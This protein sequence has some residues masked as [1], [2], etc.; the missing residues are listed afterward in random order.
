MVRP[1][2]SPAPSTGG[3]SPWE[4]SSDMRAGTH[5]LGELHLMNKYKWP[6]G[7]S[8]GG[9]LMAYTPRQEVPR[10][11]MGYSSPVPYPDLPSRRDASSITNTPFTPETSPLLSTDGEECTT[12]RPGPIISKRSCLADSYRRN[13]GRVEKRRKAPRGGLKPAVATTSVQLDKP[14]SQHMKD[15]GDIEIFD[16]KAHVHRDTRKSEVAE[17]GKVK[18]P[19]NAFLL[20]RK[21]V[22]IFIKKTFLAEEN[23]NNQQVVSRICGDSWKME[24]DEIKAKFK[25]LAQEEKKMHGK[26]FPGYKYTPKTGKKPENDADGTK[27]GNTNPKSPLTSSGGRPGDATESSHAVRESQPPIYRP[28]TQAGMGEARAIQDIH[29][30]GRYALASQHPQ[31]QLHY[32]GYSDDFACNWNQEELPP[33]GCDYSLGTSADMQPRQLPVDPSDV[34]IDPTFLPSMEEPVY[35]WH[36]TGDVMRGHQAWHPQNYSL[37]EMGMTMPDLDV[38]GAHSAYLRGAQEDWEIEQ[39]GESGTFNNWMMQEENTAT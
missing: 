28:P 11:S 37:N 16:V 33:Q 20:Y 24:T 19:L 25:K 9:G 4:R 21:H 29:A 22:I 31:Q 1:P 18:R 13:S 27:P 8:Y 36:P 12:T 30:D 10:S 34:Y 2:L 17:G 3:L 32:P 23:K 15:R 39:L 6:P 38:N 35:H 26:A 7:L 5:H 14:L